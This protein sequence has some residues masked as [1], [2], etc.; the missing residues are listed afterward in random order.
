MAVHRLR[1]LPE[2][3]LIHFCVSVGCL[4]HMTQTEHVFGDVN[5]ILF[6]VTEFVRL[7]KYAYQH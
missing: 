7:A 2:L 3:F 5:S 1:V 6:V 4:C